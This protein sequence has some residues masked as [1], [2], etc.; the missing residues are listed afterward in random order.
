MKTFTIPDIDVLLADL[1]SW[2]GYGPEHNSWVAE[3]DL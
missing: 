1:V 3:T 2:V